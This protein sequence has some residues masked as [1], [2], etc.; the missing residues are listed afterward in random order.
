MK[1]NHFISK[2]KQPILYSVFPL[3]LFAAYGTMKNTSSA[4]PPG[5][6]PG[7]MAADTL[8]GDTIDPLQE[9]TMGYPG[10]TL[11]KDTSAFPSEDFF[12]ADTTGDVFPADTAGAGEGFDDPFPADTNGLDG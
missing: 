1:R 3:A 6:N 5:I 11:P 12:P 8:P 7:V 10:D 9:D 4:I 2:L